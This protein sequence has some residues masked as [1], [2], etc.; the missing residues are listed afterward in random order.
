MR[1]AETVVNGEAID[2]Q[3][4]VELICRIRALESE[5]GLGARSRDVKQAEQS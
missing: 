1:D 4:T 5:L 3:E 2:D